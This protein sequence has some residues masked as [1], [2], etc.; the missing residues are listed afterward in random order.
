LLISSIIIYYFHGVKF[1]NNYNYCISTFIDKPGGRNRR[2][3]A[4]YARIIGSPVILAHSPRNV[5]LAH[6]FPARA[7]QFGS[8]SYF[9]PKQKDHGICHDLFIL[10]L[11]DGIE[12]PTC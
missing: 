5:R 11:V 8:I 12:P 1:K 4:L 7:H 9:F 10:E 3:A 2:A 6:F